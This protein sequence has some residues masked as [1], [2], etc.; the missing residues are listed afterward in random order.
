MTNLGS[1]VYTG[2]VLGM[3]NLF[4][5]MLSPSH[6]TLPGSV[7][8]VPWLFW[9]KTAR[10][11]M[12]IVT[13]VRDKW[14]KELV[15]RPEAS[16][17]YGT[18]TGLVRNLYGTRTVWNTLESPSR[19]PY[20]DRVGPSGVLWFNWQKCKCTDMSSRM[21][22][23]V[24]CHREDSTGLKLDVTEALENVELGDVLTKRNISTTSFSITTPAPGQANACLSGNETARKYV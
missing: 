22:A 19:C 8:A 5:S 3:S 14:S 12:R 17:V 15:I 9:T 18:R 10:P 20:D 4:K 23:V 21:G 1:H 6:I 13:I 11:L 24:W 7:R 2:L 16:L